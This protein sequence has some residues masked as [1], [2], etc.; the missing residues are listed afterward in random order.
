MEIFFFVLSIWEFS[1]D[2]HIKNLWHFLG[3]ID[4][5]LWILG[6]KFNEIKL[7]VLSLN[8]SLLLHFHNHQESSSSRIIFV[9][10]RED[11][12][13]MFWQ[14]FYWTTIWGLTFFYHS[15]I[16]SFE[17]IKLE[18]IIKNERQGYKLFYRLGFNFG[19]TFVCEY[20]KYLF[21]DFQIVIAIRALNI[22]SKY[23]QYPNCIHFLLHFFWKMYFIRKEVNEL[24]FFERSRTK[25]IMNVAFKECFTMISGPCC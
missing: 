5:P 19:I 11:L 8:P 2:I 17:M 13:E 20:C 24:A 9:I 7:G 12:T 1:I 6:I 23:L 10:L 14:I 25:T 22:E 4:F 18:L 16:D 15:F 3:I 21:Q